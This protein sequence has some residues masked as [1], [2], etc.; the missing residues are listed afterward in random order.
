MKKANKLKGAF[1][2]SAILVAVFI[3]G[4]L[5]TSSSA[6]P[7]STKLLSTSSSSFSINL[8]SSLPGKG[9]VEYGYTRSKYTDKTPTLALAK[10]A[11]TTFLING[12]KAETKVYYRVRYALKGKTKFSALAQSSITTA[13]VGEDFVFAVQADP[14]MDQASSAEVFTA[15][16]N[17]IV[18]SN[19]AFLM[20]LGDI[21]MTDKL[22]D[23]SEAS[24]RQ[25]FE[26]MKSFYDKLNGI[27][28]YFTLGNHDGELGYSNFNTKKYRKEYFPAQTG[29]LAYYSFTTPESLHIVLDIFTYTTTNP[30]DDGWQWTLGKTQYDWL[31]TTLEE[32]TAQHKFV[33][34]HHLLYGNAQ[35]RG[36]VE[37]AIFNEWGGKNR[38]GSEGFASNRPGWEKPVHQ[39]LVDNG[40]DFVF[41]GHDHIYVKQE[42]DGIIY[43]TLPQPSHPGNKTSSAAAYGYVSGKTIGGSGFLKITT[44]S[45][46]IKVEFIRSDGSIADSY[47]KNS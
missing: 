46:A 14:H 21:F 24:I 33:Y 44:N 26:F 40:V 2:S 30:K 10:G 38:D 3:F 20:D 22:Q 17:Q 39:L 37:N 32:S 34:V 12:L 23:K 9:Y 1:L 35:S 16:I 29:E 28:F 13:K 19:P 8:T 45:S 4:T 43:Q 15:T 5:P 41:K 18:K 7:I 6:S 42:L 11:A 36:G 27:P 47:I 25:R 31:K